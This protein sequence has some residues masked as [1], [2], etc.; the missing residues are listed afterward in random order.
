VSSNVVLP[1][2]LPPT[3][4]TRSP[5][6]MVSDTSWSVRRPDRTRRLTPMASMRRP[7]A[8]SARCRTLSGIAIT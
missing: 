1:V 6:S 2:P 4:A 7:S 3:I 8:V 5:G